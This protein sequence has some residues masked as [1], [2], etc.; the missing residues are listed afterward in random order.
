MTAALS[1]TTPKRR[2]AMPK[3]RSAATATAAIISLIAA[4]SLAQ[5]THTCYAF[6]NSPS[7]TS[8]LFR[9]QL[10]LPETAASRRRPSSSALSFSSRSLQHTNKSPSSS[11]VSGLSLKQQLRRRRRHADLSSALS[12]DSTA[13]ENVESTHYPPQAASLLPITGKKQKS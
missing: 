5:S 13:S 1:R 7:S 3:T 2:I 8:R 9:S 12:S 4:L 6:S 10:S 11:L